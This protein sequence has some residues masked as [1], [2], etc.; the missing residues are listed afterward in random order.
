MI[1]IKINE[2]EMTTEEAKQIYKELGD[3]FEP[4]TA[5]QSLY[6]GK[7]IGPDNFP[8]LGAYFAVV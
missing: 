1:T 7:P 4:K 8:P 6:R 2:I 3:L 5:H